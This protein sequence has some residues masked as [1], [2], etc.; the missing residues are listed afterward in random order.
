MSP[1]SGSVKSHLGL[2]WQSREPLTE[3]RWSREWLVRAIFILVVVQVSICTAGSR[4]RGRLTEGV[5]L[6]ALFASAS[7]SLASSLLGF[8]L[9]LVFGFLFVIREFHLFS[10]HLLVM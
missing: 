6:T 7:Y 8:Q 1:A 5:R 4:C 10:G 3:A 2:G 9:L